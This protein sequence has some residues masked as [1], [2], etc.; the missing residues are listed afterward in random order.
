MR[1]LTLFILFFVITQ[2]SFDALCSGYSRKNAP[3]ETFQKLETNRSL[4]KLDGSIIPCGEQLVRSLIAGQNINAGSLTVS[5]DAINLYITYNTNNNWFLKKIHLYAGPC[6][7]I[8]SNNAGNPMIGLFPYNEQFAPFVNSYTLTIPLEELDE[9]FCIS[10]HAELV[11]IGL[12][13]CV[14][15]TETGWAAGEPF[16]G[17]SWAKKFKYCKQDCPEPCDVHATVESITSSYCNENGGSAVVI[18]AGG[19]E[20]YTYTVVNT[21]TGSIYT[22]TSGNFNDL[23]NGTY[24]V[25]VHDSNLCHPECQ[26]LEFTIE[27]R[28][29]N[30]SHSVEIISACIPSEGSTVIL[31]PS[32]SNPPFLYS[33]GGGFNSNS[34]FNNLS[35]GQYLTT[36]LDANGCSSSELIT[37]IDN[38]ILSVS[39]TN[40][41]NETCSQQNGSIQLV[42]SGGEGSF[43]FTLVNAA[44]NQQ[45]VSQTGIFTNLSAG[46]YYYSVTDENGCVAQ[47]STTNLKLKN[48][49][50]NCHQI[51]ACKSIENSKI[52]VYPN[53]A[54]GYATL[55]IDLNTTSSLTVTFADETGRIVQTQ[56]I[57]D[58]D[59]EIKLNLK[60]LSPGTYMIFISDETGQLIDLT[61]LIV[62]P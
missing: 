52:N 39:V 55:S 45:Y 13:G 16:G 11:K 40:I 32:G 26:N 62:I 29:N 24:L 30:L 17:K 3:T 38:Q 58:P 35:A 42:A 15:Q 37:L 25:F 9:C 60:N 1:L 61:R 54:S 36:V 12:N 41:S 56:E 47:A 31:T 18:A 49:I 50:K 48:I 44:N 51:I 43:V 14:I 2:N 27:G 6:G 33:I 23:M 20:P 7:T 10:A 19:V 8:P 28:P 53:P 5:N 34:I 4:S 21:N 57:I 46:S 59:L 22:N